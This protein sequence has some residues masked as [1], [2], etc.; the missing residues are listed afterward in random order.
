MSDDV[1]ARPVSQLDALFRP[2]SVAVIGAS[3]D[4]TPIGRRPIAYMLRR[5]ARYAA[6][7]P[8]RPPA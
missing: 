4:P 8:A 2:R 5:L 6:G 1:V 3:A 7:R